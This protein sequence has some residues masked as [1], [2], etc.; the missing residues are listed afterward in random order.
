MDLA[1]DVTLTD[2]SR[3]QLC[4]LTSEIKNEHTVG[5]LHLRATIIRLAIIVGRFFGDL[6]VVHMTL[7]ETS[8]CDPDEAIRGA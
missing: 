1:V 7:S 2:P 8:R 3:D 5:V 6:D 4:G